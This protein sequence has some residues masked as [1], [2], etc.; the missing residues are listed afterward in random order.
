MSQGAVDVLILAALKM[1]L[2]QLLQVTGGIVS[3]WTPVDGVSPVHIATFK[4]K[5]GTIRVAAARQTRMG[6]VAAATGASRLLEQLKPRALS[7]CGVCA[8]HPDDTALGDVVISDRLFQHD[9]GKI[10][11][12]GFRG[13]LWVDPLREDW[14]RTAQDLVGPA[15]RFHGFAQPDDQSG[16]WWFLEQLLVGRN[17]QRSV[18]FARYFPDERRSASLRSFLDAKLVTLR[19]DTFMLTEFGENVIQ[20]YLALDAT[21]ASQLPFHA[22]VGPMGSGN[23]VEAA[24]TIWERLADAGMR[25]TL[26]VEMEAA[27]I[28]RV[29]HEY[30]IPFI[31]VKGVM[32]HGDSKKTDRFKD[33]AARASAEVL[34]DLL[35]RVVDP[36]APTEFL[37]RPALFSVRPDALRPDPE[38]SRSGTI[39]AWPNQHVRWAEECALWTEATQTVDGVEVVGVHHLGQTLGPL[40]VLVHHGKSTTLCWPPGCD[41]LQIT[42]AL[43]RHGYDTF[44]VETPELSEYKI[45]LDD[46][47]QPYASLAPWWETRRSILLRDVNQTLLP[48]EA[49]TQED[50]GPASQVLDDWAASTDRLALLLGEFGCGKSTLLNEWTLVRTRDRKLPLPLV[51]LLAEV[52]R[53]RSAEAAIL[54]TVRLTDTTAER[55]RL[56]LLINHDRIIPCFDGFDEFVTRVAPDEAS[57]RLRQFMALAGRGGHVLVAAREHYFGGA[58]HLSKTIDHAGTLSTRR[59]W[60]H[61][62]TP[63]RI[64]SFITTVL[65]NQKRAIEA[66]KHINH[67]Y[68]LSDLIL[69]PILFGMTLSVLEFLDPGAPVT[70]AAL[71]E[72]YI[73]RWLHQDRSDDPESLP[74][75]EK[76]AIAEALALELWN[77]GSSRCSVIDLR[78][79]AISEL[80]SKLSQLDSPSHGKILST[81]QRGGAFFVSIPDCDNFC[82]AHKSFLEFFVARAVVRR[83]A[84]ETDLLLRLRP[85]SSEILDFVT[86]ILQRENDVVIRS[87][88]VVA[89]QNWLSVRREDI[90]TDGPSTHNAF[91]L[92]AHLSRLDEDSQWIPQGADLRGISLRGNDLRKIRLTKVNLNQADLSSCDLRGVDLR[93]ANLRSSDLSF[94]RLDNALLTGAD[95]FGAKLTCTEGH[96]CDFQGVDLRGAELR[97]SVW[98]ECCWNNTTLDDNVESD[99]FRFPTIADALDLA[100]H[101]LTISR[102][103]R[104][105]IRA[106]S[107]SPNRKMIAAVNLDGLVEVFDAQGLEAIFRQSS[108]IIDNA[109][110]YQFSGYP[111]AELVWNPTSDRLTYANRHFG[112]LEMAPETANLAAPSQRHIR[113]VRWSADGSACA[114][115]HFNMTVC[116]K[117]YRDLTMT[118]LWGLP[119][120]HVRDVCF[121]PNAE[122]L[123]VASAGIDTNTAN[124]VLVDVFSREPISQTHWDAPH[125]S[126]ILAIQCIWNPETPL[127][128]LISLMVRE[129]Q[130]SGRIVERWRLHEVV[131]DDEGIAREIRIID[132]L[133][134]QAMGLSAPVISDASGSRI[135][136]I[137]VVGDSWS[138]AVY[139]DRSGKLRDIRISGNGAGFGL[140]PDG[141]TLTVFDRNGPVNQ[142]ILRDRIQSAPMIEFDDVYAV[143]TDPEERLIALRRQNDVAVLD[144]DDLHL[145]STI[146]SLPHWNHEIAWSPDGRR[147]AFSSNTDQ[148]SVSGHRI[149][150]DVIH[151]TGSAFAWLPNSDEIALLIG[152][153]LRAQN[154]IAGTDRLLCRVGSKGSRR[155]SQFSVDPTGTLYYLWGQEH[156]VLDL[157]EPLAAP[158]LVPGLESDDRPLCRSRDGRFVVIRR[159]RRLNG[160]PSLVILGIAS[161]DAGFDHEVDAVYGSAAAFSPLSLRVAVATPDGQIRI[162]EKTET[163]ESP[164]WKD[165]LKF[166]ASDTSIE[167]ILWLSGDRLLVAE[168]PSQ[169]SFWTLNEAGAQRVGVIV[170]AGDE[171]ASWTAAGQIYLTNPDTR[172]IRIA[173]SPGGEGCGVLLCPLAGLRQRAQSARDVARTLRAAGR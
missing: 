152:H 129:R 97:Q 169:I 43:R 49:T 150:D 133:V 77:S 26:A 86:D 121:S 56:R 41:T 9:E 151:C 21:N 15:V 36:T 135:A 92:L 14:L 4:G 136:T 124:F 137:S 113:N 83:L 164:S 76:V 58:T 157:R 101:P 161:G 117:S 71:Y 89:L 108:R 172:S 65:G 64:N 25:K 3:P 30:D 45:R 69:R 149:N 95:A 105:P 55:A 82:F 23:S 116:V 75:L 109:N 73:D 110:F 12:E 156:A 140:S 118:S 144:L 128:A 141:E 132:T 6:G 167:S 1:E 74:D 153:E 32:D 7:M 67:V 61:P 123:I 18:A 62:F 38:A 96:S 173:F 106:V 170:V 90:L 33:F 160:R 84:G 47:L 148:T 20:E 28:G 88:F 134:P 127:R 40:G 63:G 98:T 39:P 57:I 120:R 5:A 37:N 130:Q 27:A 78:R 155:F 154:V 22:L 107:W 19:G 163:T 79:W 165:V 31:V 42:D 100:L 29:A 8:G 46:F 80:I 66:L 115:W 93:G 60:L 53:D 87:A 59:I 34:C 142:D 81:L 111:T 17:P 70:R 99:F 72:K 138:V 146:P 139:D 171:V 112:S 54:D 35:R 11:R 44:T 166:Q 158:R 147:L 91:S 103:C 2:D 119:P 48:L 102:A 168:K 51:V 24:G 16:K 162:L 13:D 159:V 131:I 52:G 145:V 114:H 85:L 143:A 122:V 126:R 125:D 10:K 104:R 68:D 94:A 50:A